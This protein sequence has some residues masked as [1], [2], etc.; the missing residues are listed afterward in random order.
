MLC[1]NCSNKESSSH[2][3]SAHFPVYTFLRNKCK[4]GWNKSFLKSPHRS[5]H[6]QSILI[7]AC[8]L[9]KGSSV[10]S[11]HR[12]VPSLSSYRRFGL[13]HMDAQLFPEHPNVNISSCCVCGSFQTVFFF[14]GFGAG[15]PDIRIFPCEM[16]FIISIRDVALLLVNFLIFTSGVFPQQRKVK[17]NPFISVIVLK[18]SS[19]TVWRGW[20][21]LRSGFNESFWVLDIVHN[22]FTLTR[23]NWMDWM[24]L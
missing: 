19:L 6:L 21:K 13:F 10:Q 15:A 7:S 11:E 5:Q 14:S 3:L 16:F 20:R 12:R 24:G 4:Y 8:W 18:I 1:T 23:L 17:V 2:F 9:G 22:S